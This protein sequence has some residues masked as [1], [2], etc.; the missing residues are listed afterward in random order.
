MISQLRRLLTPPKVPT[1]AG[2]PE[3]WNSI[4]RRLGVAFPGDYRD[5]ITVYG[6]GDIGGTIGVV[7][8]FLEAGNL[9]AR[10]DRLRETR[11]MMQ[12][13]LGYSPVPYPVFPANGG[14]IPWGHTAFG[15]VLSWVTSEGDPNRWNILVEDSECEWEFFEESMTSFLVGI[16]SGSIESSIVNLMSPEPAFEPR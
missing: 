11:E 14:L 13:G 2:S 5:F 4:E 7:S 8:P 15:D 1:A 10:L 3:G 16:L 6:A 12:E 9:E